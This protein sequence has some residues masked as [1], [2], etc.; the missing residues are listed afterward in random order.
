MGKKFVHAKRST[1]RSCVF[2]TSFGDARKRYNANWRDGSCGETS[3]P[4]LIRCQDYRVDYVSPRRVTCANV[5][6]QLSGQTSP[7]TSVFGEANLTERLVWRDGL[8]FLCTLLGC[9]YIL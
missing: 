4:F 3:V 8:N 9:N 1:S 2:R 5:A 7:L 6:T